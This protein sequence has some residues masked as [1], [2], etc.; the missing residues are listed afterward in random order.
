MHR[1]DL[2]SPIQPH[3]PAARPRRATGDC[4]QLEVWA[5]F[6]MERALLDSAAP[7]ALTRSSAHPYIQLVH[8]DTRYVES[9][10]PEGRNLSVVLAEDSGS[11]LES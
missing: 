6:V 9:R 8:R 5:E 7:N 3:V 1:P 11:W 2:D 4:R 10:I